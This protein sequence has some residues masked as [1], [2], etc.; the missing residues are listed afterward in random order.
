MTQ[1]LNQPPG[2]GQPQQP[3]QPQHPQSHVPH[4]ASYPAPQGFRGATRQ[5]FN[6]ASYKQ[7][8]SGSYAA[9]SLILALIG[10]LTLGCLG[11]ITWPLGM[12]LGF[13]GLIGNK[14]GKGLSFAGF[15]L[16]AMGLA[17]LTAL[18]GFGM[19]GQYG[20]EKSADHAGAPVVAAIDQFKK[21]KDRVPTTLQE[22]VDEGYLPVTWD[23]GFGDADEDVQDVVKGQK[24]Q[25]FLAYQA[26]V[27]GDWMPDSSNEANK[28]LPVVKDQTADNQSFQG[29]GLAFIGIDSN[30]GTTDDAAVE[31]NQDKVFDLTSLTNVDSKT[32]DSNKTR[33]ALKNRLKQLEARKTQLERD[34]VKVAD[35]LSKH[36]ETLNRMAKDRN[37]TTLEEVKA[38]KITADALLLIGET[39]KR[40]HMTNAQLM[41]IRDKI[42]AIGIQVSRLANK[43][44]MAKLGG[45][46]ELAAEL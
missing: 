34:V 28:K 38:N 21:D 14:R 17:I 30:W 16:S 13:I 10:W 41:A 39:K 19:Y 35:D 32:R 36:E 11:V 23:Q 4:S 15:A 42:D 5:I 45:S 43:E 18:F 24:W 29:Y 27:S 40:Q 8:G 44:A 2:Y 7:P 25:S 46:P 6:P 9:A 20:A 33:N 31:Q 22:L 37:L 3:A 12:I 1:P 26:G